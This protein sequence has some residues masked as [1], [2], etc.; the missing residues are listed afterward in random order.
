[1][2]ILNWF[3]KP[4]PAVQKLP[5]GSFTVDRHGNVMTTTVASE[6]PKRLLDD[7]AREVLTLFREARS[8][9]MPLAG[10]DMNFASLRITA[11]EMQ[12][13][14]IIFLSPQNILAASSPA[15]KD[16]P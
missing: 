5:A 13:G 15:G 4:E 12:G 14:A 7:I 8:A 9:Q 16:R 10:L 6:Y 1:M 3:S 11:R 2:G